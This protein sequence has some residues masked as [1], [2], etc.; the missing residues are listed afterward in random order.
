ML[1]IVKLFRD[2][3]TIPIPSGDFVTFVQQNRAASNETYLEKNDC[4]YRLCYFFLSSKE[5]FKKLKLRLRF[6]NA[7]VHFAKTIAKQFN[8]DTKNDQSKCR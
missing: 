5:S 2:R 8:D 1:L 6:S 7:E 4:T 3:N